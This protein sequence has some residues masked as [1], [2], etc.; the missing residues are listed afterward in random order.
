MKN[1]R[2]KAALAAVICVS[3]SIATAP[4]ALASEAGVV[5]PFATLC[6]APGSTWYKTTNVVKPK[7]LTHYERFY[8]GSGATSTATYSVDHHRTLTAGVTITT[9]GSVSASA[10]IA[11]FSAESHLSLAASGSSTTGSS[12]SMTASIPN[13]KYLVLYRGNV[14]VSGSFKK[15]SCTGSGRVTT[16]ASGTGKSYGVTE[17]GSQ[18]CDLSAPSG[19]LAALAKKA[20]C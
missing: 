16:A 8:N 11:S 19:S 10:V 18:R 7:K 3:G 12:V 17:T 2:V 14:Q 20:A 15:Y 9:G 1:Y 5:T 13:K 4:A 6:N